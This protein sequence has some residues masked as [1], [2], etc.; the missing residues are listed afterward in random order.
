MIQSL[1]VSLDVMESEIKTTETFL[2]DYRE[3]GS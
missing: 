3:N 1:G 2:L